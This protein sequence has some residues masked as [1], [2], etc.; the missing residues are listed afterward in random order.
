[1]IENFFFFFLSEAA[2]GFFRSGFSGVCS[3]GNLPMS[4][5]G[6]RDREEIIPVASAGAGRHCGTLC[7]SVT[8]LYHPPGKNS[9]KKSNWGIAKL[10]GAWYILRR[11]RSRRSKH[12]PPDGRLQ[13]LWYLEKRIQCIKMSSVH[14]SNILSRV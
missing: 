5:P 13:K 10:I 3:I 1:M 7:K 11:C 8:R 6:T 14:P 12:G 9:R 4:K 2:P